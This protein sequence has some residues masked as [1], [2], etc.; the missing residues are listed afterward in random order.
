MTFARLSY[1]SEA[2][3]SRGRGDDFVDA[4]SLATFIHAANDRNDVREFD[5]LESILR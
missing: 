1:T 3:D 4:H 2:R 5:T